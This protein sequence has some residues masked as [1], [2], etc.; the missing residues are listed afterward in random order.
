MLKETDVIKILS[1]YSSFII[2]THKNCDGDGL[3][4]GFALYY[5][6]EQLGKKVFFRTL[7]EPE[8]KYRFLDKDNILKPYDTVPL[9]EQNN[10]AVLALDTNDFRLLNPFYDILKSKGWPVFFIDHHSFSDKSL[11]DCCFV[12]AK[13]ASTGEL[14]YDLLKALKISFNES[15]A[16]ALYTSIV[17]DTKFFRHIKNSSRSFTISAELVPYISDTEM[18]YENLFK[19]LEKKNLGFFQHFKK[20]EYYHQNSIGIL[21]LCERDFQEHNARI[22]QAYEMM[23]TVMNIAS[24]E[25]TALILEKSSGSFKLSLRS[26]KKSILSVAESFKG[27]GHSLAAGAYIKDKSLKEIK[28]QVLSGFLKALRS[29]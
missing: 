14:I 2:T 28:A 3:G 1:Q 25:M 10:M 5:G 11:R 6:L 24:M 29:A 4:A 9:P 7:E 16:T 13:A 27:G 8:K 26:R 17:F 18:I 19:H 22:Q 20:V 23:E 12:N 15:I 21:Y